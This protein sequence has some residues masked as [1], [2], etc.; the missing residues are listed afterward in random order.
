MQNNILLFSLCHRLIIPYLILYIVKL[1]N[2]VQQGW[3]NL[4][5]YYLSDPIISIYPIND[6]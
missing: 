2:F 3:Y 1:I 5:L 6:N 4:M